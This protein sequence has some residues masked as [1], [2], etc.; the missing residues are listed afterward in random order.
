[1]DADVVIVGAGLAGLSCADALVAAG[2]DVLVV[3]ARERV[4][5]RV[6]NHDLGDG[7]ALELGGQ[8]LGLGQDRAAALAARL[9]LATYPTHTAGA[10]LLEVADGDVRR[11][12]GALAPIGPIALADVAQARARLGLL[13][14]RVRPD[15]RRLDG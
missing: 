15:R 9:G 14:R 12:S 7:Q 4:G 3:E 6:L 2:L 5:G 11:F 13:A 10:T 8:W 1:M